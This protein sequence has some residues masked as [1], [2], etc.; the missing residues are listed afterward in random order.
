MANP[1]PTPQFDSETGVKASHLAKLAKRKEYRLRRRA[2]DFEQQR[3][4]LDVLKT[5]SSNPAVVGV[6]LMFAVDK[7]WPTGTLTPAQ[8]QT[9][10]AGL[11]GGIGGL[12]QKILTDVG[13]FTSVGS[14]TALVGAIATTTS[15]LGNIVGGVTKDLVLISLGLYTASG[16]NLPGVLTASGNALQ[17]LLAPLLSAGAAAGA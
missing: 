1:H 9:A 8:A 2:Q 3:A 15:N 14:P 4:W 13:I 12:L 17:G 16:G 10:A 7:F 6:G 5:L 11:P